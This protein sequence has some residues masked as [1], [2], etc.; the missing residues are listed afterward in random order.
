MAITPTTA[1]VTAA[2][3]AVSLRLPRVDST[4]GPPARMKINDGK[5]VNQVATQAASAAPKNSASGPSTCLAQ[6]PTK[7]TNA[8]MMISGPGVVSPSAKPSII[9]GVVSHW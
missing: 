3:G 7:P 8:T 6:P 9:C 1:A 2:S 4:H 5:N